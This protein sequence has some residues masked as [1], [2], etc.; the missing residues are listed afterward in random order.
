MEK[1]LKLEICKKKYHEFDQVLYLK[2]LLSYDDLE[3]TPI[4]FLPGQEKKPKEVFTFIEKKVKL[5][6]TQAV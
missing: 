6:L 3:E 5:F 2:A 4:K 1:E